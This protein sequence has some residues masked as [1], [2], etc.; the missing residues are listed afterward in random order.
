MISK[1]QILDNSKAHLIQQDPGEHIV[2]H[3]AA[4]GHQTHTFSPERV[5][6][7]ERSGQSSCSR[8]LHYVVR[9]REVK[10]HSHAD[11]FVAHAYHVIDILEHHFKCRI[12]GHATSHSI[13]EQGAYRGGD[14]AFRVKRE[15]ISGRTFRSH[16]HDPRLQVHSVANSA[17]G[18]DTRSLSDG[19]VNNI[20]I[21]H[22]GKELEPIG[23]YSF[24]N[25]AMIVRY[26]VPSVLFRE[27]L[28]MLF[29]FLE[30]AAK[31]YEVA[32][33][34]P[35]GGVFLC[36]VPPRYHD[37]RWHLEPARR[38]RYRLAV[39]AASRGNQPRRFF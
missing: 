38:Q 35:H 18:A 9:V 7:F 20:Q 12:I 34:C 6:L 21:G 31:L 16:S 25:V 26:E 3:V 13:G 14:L 17:A 8:T 1:D 24:D 32:T 28:R 30:V 22:G 4:G 11:L 2:V 36:A 19:H 23:S 27:F 37:V 15:G 5:L 29:R 39:I 33:L 10:L